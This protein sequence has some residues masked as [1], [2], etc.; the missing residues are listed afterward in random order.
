MSESQ[1]ITLSGG[2]EK[3]VARDSDGSDSDDVPMLVDSSQTS[4]TSRPLTAS[5]TLSH[6]QHGA[7]ASPLL[8][9]EQHRAADYP[10]VPL[11]IVTGWLGS[12]KTTLVQHVLHEL[13]ATGKRVAVINNEFAAVGVERKLLAADGNEVLGDILELGNGC[14]CCSVRSDLLAALEALTR[15]CRFDYVVVE[16][17][18]LANPGALAASFWADDAIESSV[19]LDAIVSVVDACFLEGHLR[20]ECPQARQVVHQIA[21]ADCVLVNK[22][23]LV[24]PE[25]LARLERRLRAINGSARMV[26]CSFA[27]VP[28][29]TVLDLR[30]FD[31]SS[32][33]NTVDTHGKHNE[34]PHAHTSSCTHEH[35]QHHHHHGD[36]HDDDH[37]HNPHCSREASAAA[38]ALIEADADLHDRTIT[39]E[40]FEVDG[41]TLRCDVDRLRTWLAAVLWSDVAQGVITPPGA[42]HGVPLPPGAAPL[43]PSTPAA[44]A[45]EAATIGRT[46]IF[47]LKA[48]LAVRGGDSR[49]F[50]VQGVQALFEVEPAEAEPWLPTDR[51]VSKLVVIG[52]HLDRAELEKGFRGCFVMG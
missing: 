30:A 34:H 14:I 3:F 31:G 35:H 29:T 23:D 49:R 18:G 37:H 43:D 22:A 50:Y 16:C 4:S 11:T 51:I 19:R 32:I 7:D 12:G 6:S 48:V 10:P 9:D 36:H 5:S 33:L 44:A 17:S 13:G 46:Q 41:A 24:Q 38:S 42:N 52:R 39:T 28:L 27:R 2:D 21:F 15:L 20:D 25:H 1:N 26:T 40:V 8:A 45:D 47:R